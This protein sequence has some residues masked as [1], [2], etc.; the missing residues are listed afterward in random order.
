[1]VDSHEAQQPNRRDAGL[2]PACLDAIIDMDHS[3]VQ[4]CGLVPWATVDEA[5]G[6]HYRPLGRPATATQLM[7]GLH[8]L[9][10]MRD[11]SDEGVVE[12]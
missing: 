1:M 4:L 6:E 9:T 5:F 3:L 12:C 8:Y 11:L 2:F 7:V 10:H